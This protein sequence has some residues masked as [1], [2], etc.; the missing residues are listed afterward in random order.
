MY[1][2]CMYIVYIIYNVHLHVQVK[3][4]MEAY[5]FWIHDVS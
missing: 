4:M 1:D 2:T 3:V 5:T